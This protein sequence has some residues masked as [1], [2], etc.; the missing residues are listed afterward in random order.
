[1]KSGRLATQALASL[2]L[3]L[4]LHQAWL[5]ALESVEPPSGR[6]LWQ[7]EAPPAGSEGFDPKDSEILIAAP[8]H[9]DVLDPER[10]RAGS[11][12]RST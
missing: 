11:L 8:N 12:R 3:G 9:P 4:L 6:F 2:F 5:S 7:V 10:L 1:M